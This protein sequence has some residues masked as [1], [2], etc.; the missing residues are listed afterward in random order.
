MPPARLAPPE[1]YYSGVYNGGTFQRVLTVNRTPQQPS[2]CTVQTVHVVLVTGYDTAADA[3]AF[4]I[5]NSWGQSWGQDGFARMA[6]ILGSFGTCGLYQVC[7]AGRPLGRGRGVGWDGTGLLVRSRAPAPSAGSPRA[8]TSSRASGAWMHAHFLARAWHLQLTGCCHPPPALPQYG[9]YPTTTA[10]LQ[11][12]AT[13]S[14]GK[15]VSNGKV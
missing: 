8:G 7:G 9:Y 15:G 3:P 12:P 11:L 5:R 6:M 13:R 10:T 1:F 14:N 4:I 2:I